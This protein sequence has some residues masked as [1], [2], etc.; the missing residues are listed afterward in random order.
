GITLK[1]PLLKD[2]WID[3]YRRN[4]Q[5]QKQN[6]KIADLALRG[7]IMSNLTMVATAYYDLVFAREQVTVQ[8][9]AMQLAQRLLDDTRRKVQA[10][11][12]TLLDEKQEESNLE[13]I[14]TALF[15]AEQNY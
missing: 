7:E 12:L 3:Q 6:L 1:Q 9:T 4:I 13:V 8:T 11:L 14:Q 10:G 2:F 5:I 15:A